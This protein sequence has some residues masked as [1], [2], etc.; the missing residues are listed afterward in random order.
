MKDVHTLYL[1]SSCNMVLIH[2][3]ILWSSEGRG[4]KCL[5][6]YLLGGQGI[7]SYY[8]F[9]HCASD[10]MH[11]YNINHHGSHLVSICLNFMF[12]KFENK[13]A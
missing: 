10:P 11:R 13:S 12:A 8:I 1:F 3:A 4:K 2:R 5:G 7:K 9:C 6:R